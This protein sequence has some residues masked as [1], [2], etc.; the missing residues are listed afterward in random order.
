M[1]FFLVQPGTYSSAR[2][3]RLGTVTGLLSFVPRC[4]TGALNFML[5]HCFQEV[6]FHP[7]A[8]KRD[9]GEAD[10]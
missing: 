7:F 5:R 3:A 4:G 10:G 6:V 9:A 2:A 1:V 8:L